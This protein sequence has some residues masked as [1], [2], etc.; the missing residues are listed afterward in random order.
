MSK[1]KI[2]SYGL[3]DTTL[4][5]IFLKVASN[6]NDGEIV[7]NKE[8]GKSYGHVTNRV[9]SASESSGLRHLFNNKKKAVK[10][11]D[12]KQAGTMEYQ[13]DILFC[14]SY[15]FKPMVLCSL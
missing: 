7:R 3:S 11:A 1:L 14:F 5:E 8:D 13:M 9:R 2:K 4:E 6:V 10:E 12:E 15:N